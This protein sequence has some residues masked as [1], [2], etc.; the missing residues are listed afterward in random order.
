VILHNGFDKFATALA[1]MWAADPSFRDKSAEAGIDYTRWPDCQG[2]ALISQYEAALR[3]SDPFKAQR[4]VSQLAASLSLTADLDLL[5]DS[6]AD[7]SAAYK[8]FEFLQRASQVGYQISQE[9]H[10]A[11]ELFAEL[12]RNS[13]SDAGMFD[14]AEISQ[15][16]F[17]RLAMEAAAKKM[18]KVIPGW[19]KLSHMIAGFNPGRVGM[20]LAE[21]G[22]G[23]SNLCLSLALA[24]QKSMRV[25]YF[26][27]EML[28][29]DMMD[30]V[31]VVTSGVSWSE[32]R[33]GHIP[34]YDTIKG[35]LVPG[36]FMMSDG[37]NKSVEQIART[38]KRYNHERSL[39]L[40]VVDYDQKLLLKLDRGTPEWMA[41]KKAFEDL[42][43]LA[44][45]TRTYIL[46]AAQ[47]SDDEGKVSGSLRSKYP[48]SVV[49]FF[50][51]HPEHGPA[52]SLKK[53]RFETDRNILQVDY[54]RQSTTVKEREIVHAHRA[55]DVQGTKSRATRVVFPTQTLST[56]SSRNSP[57]NPSNESGDSE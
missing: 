13:I 57:F 36:N 9:P 10:R 16:Q 40:V 8:G 43:A 3:E 37:V 49:M 41:L 55:P 19:E 45:E 53:N 30:R 42:E 28:I 18:V 31:H 7:L 6:L 25:I 2:K 21:S 46:I 44:K 26:N 23:K 50:H 29:E 32:L 47:A 39:D 1:V 38:V 5:P 35:K 51:D 27:M 11:Y 17:N 34:L 14:V 20:I 12:E 15:D 48:C 56:Y 52:I 33:R 54:D 4:S 22:F 24:A